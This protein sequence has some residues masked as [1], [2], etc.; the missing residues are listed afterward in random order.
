MGNGHKIL[1]LDDDADFRELCQ[2]LLATLT[3][4]PEISTASTGA[5]AIAML[6]S[7]PFS[8][9]LTD[10]KMPSMDGFQV[11]S[12]VRRRFPNLRTIVMTGEGDENFRSRAYAIGIDL[13][14]E[15]PKTSTEIKLFVD[16]VESL[17]DREQQGGFRGVQSKSLADLVQMECLSQTSTT[18]KVT[19]GPLIGK[20]WLLNGELIDADAGEV[21]GEDAFKYVMSWRSGT[22][23]N[24]PAEPNR[25]R[26]IFN[27]V[28]GLLLD[29]AQTM[30][31]IAAGEVPGSGGEKEDGGSALAR[32]SKQAPGV[33]F[34]LTASLTKKKKF[35][36]HACENADQVAKWAR[37][38]FNKF[39]SMGEMLK[40]GQ[41]S[42]VVA[43]GSQRNAGLA[44]N[45]SDVIC[46]GTNS[47]M[48]PE[49]VLDATKKVV[50]QWAS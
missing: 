22:F 32:L 17:L 50:A 4:E 33:E 37:D 41:L 39:S 44:S 19:N 8:L 49:Q 34:V 16:C 6:E 2:E 23:E 26:V 45:G 13:F 31:E 40:A 35:E 21:K 18:L 24:L 3:S 9:L 11:L 47:R 38:T 36:H 42:H 27:S 48:K 28:Q 14:V 15:K 30:D 25:E 10:L 20:I 12:V 7:E 43:L 29:S 5:H 46:V 1:V